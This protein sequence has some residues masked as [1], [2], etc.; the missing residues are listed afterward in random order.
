[1][2]TKP[3][4]HDRSQ[5]KI[6]ILG[7]LALICGYAF[8]YFLYTVMPGGAD[9]KTWPF[10]SSA[11]MWFVMLVLVT[12][13]I[14][15]KQVGGAIVVGSAIALS[16]GSRTPIQVIPL[17]GFILAVVWL[18]AGYVR[19][20]REVA[21]AVNIHFARIAFRAC[22]TF[23][24][25]I[26]LFGAFMLVSSIQA[27]GFS[28]PREAVLGPLQGAEPIVATMIPGFSLKSSI[29]DVVEDVVR[30]KLG[31]NVPDAVVEEAI[32]GV[33]QNARESLEMSI[34]G[35]ELV[36]D[37]LY[38]ILAEKLRALSPSAQTAALAGIGV[39]MFLFAKGL[40]VIFAYIAIACAFLVYHGAL[41][42]GFMR[43]ESVEARRE[44]IVL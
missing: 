42:V 15:K 28:I 41:A 20:H 19:V 29:H 18:I 12:F 23:V 9:A 24:T 7:V 5:L 13:L 2:D 21:N 11:V 33:L 6:G 17:T 31:K 26:A 22:Q 37:V 27:N 44:V 3:V 38:A 35:E 43:I 30:E 40:G 1:M 34:Q 25:A 14:P 32:R 4:A 8:G 36:G 39:L 16:I 10:F